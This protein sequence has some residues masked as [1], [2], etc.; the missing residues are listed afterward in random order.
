MFIDMLLE[1]KKYQCYM[2]FKHMALLRAN[3]AFV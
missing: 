1:K 3:K 2:S